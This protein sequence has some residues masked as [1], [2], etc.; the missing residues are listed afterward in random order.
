MGGSSEWEK[1]ITCVS[2]TFRVRH[3]NGKIP[4]T[5]PH[6]NHSR[7]FCELRL[8]L[9]LAGCKDYFASSPKQPSLV[10]SVHPYRRC[11]G[12]FRGGDRLNHLQ[13]AYSTSAAVSFLI[14]FSWITLLYMMFYAFSGLVNALQ[15]PKRR[16]TQYDELH[17]RSSSCDAGR[18]YLLRANS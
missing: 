14:S 5:P 7:L 11:R 18:A 3:E 10:W 9:R 8:S 17:R 12:A 13:Q 2:R 15:T 4:S 1:A 16:T 6:R